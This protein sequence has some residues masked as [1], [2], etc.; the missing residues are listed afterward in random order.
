MINMILPKKVSELLNEDTIILKDKV[1]GWREAVELAGELLVNAGA[2]E[3]RYVKSMIKMVEKYG[4]YIV[5]GN[6]IAIPHARPEDGVRKIGLSLVILKTATTFQG[7][8]DS[9]IDILF[10]IAAVDSSSHLSVMSNL[11]GMLSDMSFL[12]KIRNATNSKEILL[13]IEGME[14]EDTQEE[15]NSN[16]KR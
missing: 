13:L 6:G 5:L 9:P 10:G 11:V 4:S 8:E 14:K 15:Y 1:E 7:R 12:N 2:V 3:S 16:V